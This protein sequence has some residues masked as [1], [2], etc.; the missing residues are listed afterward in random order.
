MKLYVTPGLNAATHLSDYLDTIGVE[1]T[2]DLNSENVDNF[3]LF[4]ITDQSLP[5][6]EN[7][8]V[9]YVVDNKLNTAQFL[10]YKFGIPGSHKLNDKWELQKVLTTLDMP[11]L[12]TIY[13][14]TEQDIID[15]FASNGTIFCKPTFHYGSTDPTLSVDNLFKYTGSTESYN[16]VMGSIVVPSHTKHYYNYYSSY[17]EFIADVDIEEF[18]NIQN[19]TNALP[20]HQ[21]ILQQNFAQDSSTWNH[22]IVLG[23]VDGQNNIMHE[24]YLIGARTNLNANGFETDP[25]L[26]S[27]VYFDFDTYSEQ[28][29]INILNTRH[30]QGSDSY[31]M[32]QKLKD[33]F[34][35]ADVRNTY[36]TG[37]GYI[38]E[39]NEPVF[40]DFSTGKMSPAL[41]RTW[42][43]P[44][45]QL[46]RLKFMLDETYDPTKLQTLI[47]RFWFELRIETP[48]TNEKLRLA[49]DYKIKFMLP[50]KEGFTRIPCT[51]YG[52]TPQE[53]AHNV[54]EYI[55]IC[56][57]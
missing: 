3:V 45:Q 47:H 15:F 26:V 25:E 10:N 7:D 27:K 4:R 34:A 38:N 28:D 32:E 52:D 22:F 46:N 51:A 40:F 29:I 24:P 8:L 16:E 41:R 30:I 53:V 42:L 31:N 43:T 35:E 23:Y 56:K 9:P 48:I 6:D 12:N 54:K 37:Q 11:R 13:P 21:C 36:F 18:L 20:M 55:A 57:Q 39:N 17:E 14:K 5:I 19:S 2:T 33:I 44:E 50:V 49:Q 1:S